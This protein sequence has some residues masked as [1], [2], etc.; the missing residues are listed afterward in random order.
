MKKLG[1]KN[2]IRLLEKSKLKFYKLDNKYI[3]PF[4]EAYGVFNDPQVSGAYCTYADLLFDN[5]LTQLK[6]RIEKETELELTE[7]YTYARNYKMRDELERHKDR[8]W[9]HSYY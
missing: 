1:F 3:N 9:L 6:P 7:M 4:S 8:K 5:I 2:N